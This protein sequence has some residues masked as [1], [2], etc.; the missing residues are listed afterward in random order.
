MRIFIN[1]SIIVFTFFILSC[2]S[3]SN[4]TNN[5]I[6]FKNKAPFKIEEATYTS[7]LLEQKSLK[8]L[9]VHIS[10]NNPSIKLDSIYFRNTAVKLIEK[11]SSLKNY[12]EGV[13]VESYSIPLLNLDSNPRN[14]FGNKVPNISQK[15][16]F[17]LTNSEAIITY[18]INNKLFYFKIFNIQEIRE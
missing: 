7:K 14:E 3:S 13:I 2:S 8:E 12:F 9:T 11:E 17:K 4:L 16:P 15:I 6:Q 1:S 18:Y 10:I 5:A